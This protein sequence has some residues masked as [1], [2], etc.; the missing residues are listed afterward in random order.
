MKDHSLSGNFKD[1]KNSG[2]EKKPVIGVSEGF[3]TINSLS[4]EN[5]ESSMA[6]DPDK[7]KI[8]LANFIR[9]SNSSVNY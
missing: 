4:A 2:G 5:K 6:K 3:P 7:S 1:S 9:G 8:I